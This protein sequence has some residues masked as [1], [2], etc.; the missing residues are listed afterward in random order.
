MNLFTRAN[1]FYQFIHWRLTWDKRNTH[2][3]FTVP[4][5]PKFMGPRD[6]VKLIKD[7]SVVGFSGLAANHR[8]SIIYW[9]MREVFEE[10]GHPCGLTAVALGGIGGRGKVPGTLEEIGQEGLTTR[11]VTGHTETFKSMLRLA[12]KGKLDLQCLPQGLMALLFAE[13]GEGRN[14]VVTD[15]GTGTFMDPR[16]GRGS[17]VI[18][19]DAEQL[20]SVEENG[21]LRYTCPKLDVA[22]FN[23]PSADKKGNIYAKNC[24]MKAESYE[25]A[26]AAKKNG[27]IVIANVGLVV[28]E[29]W[30]DVWIPAEDVDAVVVYP[31]T[32][33]TGSV[34]HRKYWPMFTTNSNLS[35]N[36]GIERVR[37]IN[38]LVGVTP[39]RNAVDNA[40]ARLGASL[41]VEN[42]PKGGNADI[43]VGLPE[44][45]SRLL[46]ESGALKHVTLIT[47]SGVLGG[48]A[49]PGIFF[50]AAVNPTEIVSSA[51]VFRRMYTH[52]DAA[53]LGMLQAD[54]EGNI[55]VSKRGEGAINYVGPGGF[56]DITTCAKMTFFVGSWGDRA[57]IQIENG[58]MKILNPGKP[59]FI[60]KVDEITFSGQ[61]ALK[62]GKKIFYV[63]HLGAFQLTPRGMELIRVMPG[64]DIQKDIIGAIPMKV[65]LP[66]SGKVPVV[67]KS[68]ITGEGFR[69]AFPE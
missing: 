20:I 32:E 19:K 7:G 68:I 50:G 40:L 64:I 3:R 41:F 13:M 60:D 16:V 27:G 5:N 66:E 9:S 42:F 57:Q 15:T 38:K 69:L 62:H 53:I 36:E 24:L 17:P 21:K 47:E 59:K 10:T 4:G 23:M 11:M 43:G 22:V 67:D 56:I 44:E 34:P 35:I 55:N 8:S 37:F 33:Q 58:L 25:M 31:G 18:P 1:I 30:G 54:S 29:G 6:A 28:E 49:A 2:Y 65:V 45:V 12:D 39:K 46:Y 52:L 26:K 48:L 63:T 51:E 61:E 14:F